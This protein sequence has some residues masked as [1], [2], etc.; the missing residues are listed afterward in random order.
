MAEIV[1]TKFDIIRLHLVVDF[2]TYA[3]I[4][5]KKIKPL[6]MSTYYG[7]LIMREML[8]FKNSNPLRFV[9]IKR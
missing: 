7:I 3:I 2:V 6:E 4:F 9:E 8:K 5:A 1:T